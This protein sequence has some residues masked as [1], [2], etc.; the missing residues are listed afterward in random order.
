MILQIRQHLSRRRR[1]HQRRRGGRGGGG[2]PIGDLFRGV[3]S[4]EP[5]FV[6][7]IDYDFAT[8]MMKYDEI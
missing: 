2:D 3:S 1:G 4:A 5:P 7:I 8:N 6:I